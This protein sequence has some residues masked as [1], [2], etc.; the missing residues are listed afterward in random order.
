MIAAGDRQG[1]RAGS[2]KIPA[3]L[4]GTS[5]DDRTSLV[6]VDWGTASTRLPSADV[7]EQCTAGR[8]GVQKPAKARWRAY[9]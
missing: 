4:A 1:D 7:M 6:M 8:L 9:V 3:T 2:K 5:S